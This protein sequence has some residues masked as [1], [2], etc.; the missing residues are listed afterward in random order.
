L[1]TFPEKSEP[2]RAALAEGERLL[3]IRS[4]VSQALEKARADKTITNSLEACVTLQLQDAAEL[5]RWQPRLAE[6]EEFL[7]L[8]ELKL[9]VGPADRA[10][11]S[12]TAAAKC[13]RCWRHRPSVGQHPSHPDL[14]D[15]CAAALSVR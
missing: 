2:D 1:Q 5:E 11:V 10:T 9:A 14:C 8:S 13:Q 15:R 3:A 7:I 12:K 6:L 4:V